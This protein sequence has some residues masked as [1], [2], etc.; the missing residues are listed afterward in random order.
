VAERP[1]P[2]PYAPFIAAA[3]F[4]YFFLLGIEA[5]P[6]RRA[7]QELAG[8]DVPALDP[9]IDHVAAGAKMLH[10]LLDG[11]FIQMS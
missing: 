8:L 2:Q 7:R 10:H 4:A 6:V 3:G 1:T 5:N 9:V 11:Q